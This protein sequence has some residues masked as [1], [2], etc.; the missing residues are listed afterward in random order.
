METVKLNENSGLMEAIRYFSDPL[1]CLE[2]V[3]KAKWPNGP[4]C[5]R[6]GQ[7]TVLSEDAAD[8]DMP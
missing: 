6:C 4:E 5:P 7:E 2:A 8:L 1:I 3:S